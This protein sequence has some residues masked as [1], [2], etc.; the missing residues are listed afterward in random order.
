MTFFPNIESSGSEKQDYEVS[1]GADPPVEP[2][3][4]AQQQMAS[5]SELSDTK[6]RKKVLSSGLRGYRALIE[7]TVGDED[8]DAKSIDILLPQQ[9][10][11][12]G[13]E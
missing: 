11:E 6:L 3:S 13:Q 12:R 5:P 2:L 4:K 10:E 1:P 7:R 8:E 9:R